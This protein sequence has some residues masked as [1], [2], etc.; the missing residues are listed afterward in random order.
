S[1]REGGVNGGAGVA[2]GEK[3]AVAGW[4]FGI[5]G[6]E[7]EDRTV[8]DSDDVGHGEGG[9]DVG[10]TAAI[11][12]AQDVQADAFGKLAEFGDVRFAHCGASIAKEA[13]GFKRVKYFSGHR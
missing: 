3:K 10:G 9:A 11:S 6:V 1:F 4:V 7:F 8:K 2:F 12:H 5:G 13:G